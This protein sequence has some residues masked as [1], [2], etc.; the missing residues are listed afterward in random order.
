MPHRAEKQERKAMLLLIKK[1]NNY[2]IDLLPFY[3]TCIH[4]GLHVCMYTT[5]TF[6]VHRGRK[7]VL[8]ILELELPMALGD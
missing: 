2:L 6:S 8:D 7:K 5:C 3:F 4:F 1:K